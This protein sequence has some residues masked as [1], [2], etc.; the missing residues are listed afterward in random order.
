VPLFAE[1]LSLRWAADCF[2]QQIDWKKLGYAGPKIITPNE[3]IQQAWLKRLRVELHMPSLNITSKG[4][5]GGYGLLVS[6]PAETKVLRDARIVT[7]VSLALEHRPEKGVSVQADRER[8]SARLGEAVYA[9]VDGRV[10]ESPS[11]LEWELI[12]D[13]EARRGVW[14]ELLME[15]TG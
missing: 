8:L 1:T 3:D 10:W 7:L 11:V 12:D 14:A 2:N 15:E 4:L 13:L 5:A 6:V 9:R